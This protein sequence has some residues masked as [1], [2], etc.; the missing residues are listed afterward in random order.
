M[1]ILEYIQ[2]FGAVLLGGGLGFWLKANN[3]TNLQ[4]VLS[5]SGAYILGITALH[6]MPGVFFEGNSSAGL[7]LLLGFVIQLLLEQ[8]SG[9]VE[10]G[11]IHALHQA[12]TKLAIPI[13]L[14]LSFHAFLEGIPL[15]YYESFTEV[16]LEHHH[17]HEHLLYGIILHKAPAAFAL[18]ILLLSSQ[19]SNKATWVCLLIFAAMSPLGSFVGT[20][21]PM[22]FKMQQI[23]LAIVIGSFLHISTTILFEVD[24][25]SHHKIS[26]K[27]MGVIFLGL[28]MAMFT[29]I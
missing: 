1:D 25:T 21:I 7:W 6:L 13:M 26:F 4:L 14:G 10:H 3:K 12:S 5:F 8:F 19:F 29:L 9:G 11:H 20:F 18:V 24:T 16:H 28:G 2:L 17:G 22:D 27:K 15:S 23:F